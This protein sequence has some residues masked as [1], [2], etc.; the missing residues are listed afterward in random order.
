MSQG[1][2]K[3]WRDRLAQKRG[4]EEAR[5]LATEARRIL[6]A[7][8]DRIPAAVTSDVEAAASAVDASLASNDAGALRDAVARLDAKMDEHLSFA[9][10][11]ALREYG[12]SIGVAIA[13]ALLLR[14]FVI[15][16]FQIPSG[17]MIPT[18]EIG[19]HI[20]VSKFSYGIGIPFTY[21]KVLQF[22]TPK[23][24]DVIVFR[25]PLDPEIDYIKRVVALPGERVEIRKNE[26]FVNGKSM[27]R[28]HVKGPCS[29]ED[30]PPS[31]REYNCERWIENLD[32]KEH[33]VIHNANSMPPPDWTGNVVPP[34]HVFVMGDNRDNSND[35]RVWGTVPMELIKGRALIV[36]W[37]RPPTEGGLSI[38]GVREF[39]GAIRFG[40]FFTLVK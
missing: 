18:L 17:S 21:K 6:R 4:E 37:S 36:W 19:D 28:E 16:A 38:E 8:Q 2:L 25:Y 32:G 35:S 20:F 31:R 39:F 23:R 12:E 24:G 9:R 34:N 30:T 22:G 13:I 15:E 11:S 40:R 3:G 27:A 5:N 7:K 14:A 10:K 29:Y 33:S 26:V 1:E